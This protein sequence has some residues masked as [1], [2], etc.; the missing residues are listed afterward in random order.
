MKLVIVESPNKCHT[1]S[2]YLGDD[3][4]VIA[5]KGIIRDLATSGKGG[6]GVDVK[7]N[8]KPTYK[9]CSSKF[10]T[11]NE[12]KREAKNASEVI[13]ATDPDREGEAIA[14]S[15]A[16]VLGLNPKKNKRLE[17][18]EI[19]RES[20]ETAINNPTVIDMNLV[21]SQETRRIID[22]ILGFRLTSLIQK[23][24]KSKS[25][26]R[27]QSATLKLI[28]DHDEE[29]KNFKPEEYWKISF[30]SSKD[31]KKF[32]SHFLSF[33]DMKKIT[34][35]DE[36]ELVIKNI[37][38]TAKVTEIKHSFR[39]TESKPAFTTSTLQQEAYNV[40]G[41]STKRTASVAQKLYEGI[42]V[43]GEHV[44]L[45]TY[46]R[47]DSTYLSNTYVEHATAY[48]LEKFGSD[49]VGK[50]KTVKVV[51]AQNA[52]EAIRPT[53]NHRTPESVV[54]YLSKDEYKLYKLIYERT[55]SSLMT[56]KKESVVS[57]KLQSNDVVFEMKGSRVVFEG[58]TK[59]YRS[60][61]NNS[62][63]LPILKEGD[64]VSIEKLINE[65]DF[66]KPPSPYSEGKIV[67]LM[68]E[69][70]IGRPST[71]ASTIDTLVKRAYVTS[72]KGV[73]T[74]TEQGRLTAF[75]LNKYCPD[76]INVKYTA[77]MEADLD[78]IQEGEIDKVE[79]LNKFY[80]E[81]TKI[82]DDASKKMYDE[83]KKE[84]GR[85]CPLCGAPLVYNNGK[86]G[87]FVACSAFPKCKYTEK[88]KKEVIVIKKCPDCDGD[89]VVKGKGRKKFLGCSN[90]PACKHIEQ[91]KEN[92]KTK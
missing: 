64:V 15:V 71:Y 75:V 33:K 47:T 12:I 28:C 43:N 81:F 20:I 89:L 46:I 66:T 35:K 61:V 21:N 10:S 63:D 22:R 85:N 82:V 84:V 24:I 44:G 91:Y 70:N 73:I 50:R 38:K 59:L 56:A 87:E 60:E 32:V 3:Y 6:Y 29:I 90:Y 86:Y 88:Q 23:R 57:V 49:Y 40:Y 53:S 31:N 2:R 58:Y 77:D 83:P 30:E 7:N 37:G 25:A 48:L 39:S 5:T 42:E 54:R 92:K 68:E 34:S 45:I 26:G 55:L 16:E 27:V 13:L 79:I 18:H 4:K 41:F 65:Q 51:G 9:I 52:H 19:T 67:K 80:S 17:F 74:S 62:D 72:D 78:K 1:I 36:D 8:F 11:V 14:F 76:L 69:K